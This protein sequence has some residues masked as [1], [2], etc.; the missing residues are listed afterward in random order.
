MIVHDLEQGSPEWFETRM[1]IPTASRF[2]EIMTPKTLKPAKTK[3]LAHLLAEYLLG[4]PLDWGSTVITE[5][6]QDLEAE[7][8]D[9]YAFQNDADVLPVGFVTRENGLVGGSPDRLVGDDG[10]LEIKNLMA[11]GHVSILIEDQPDPKHVSQ[12]QGYLYLT[13]RKWW[14]LLY[15]NPELPKAVFRIQRDPKWQAAWAPIIDAFVD[16]LKVLRMH[17]ESDRVPRPWMEV[18]RA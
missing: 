2:H 16:R 8:A 17:W 6:G 3:Y 5:R 13:D 12:V 18:E 9:W 1:G 7:A 15:Y 14:D 10:G 11:E 4:Q